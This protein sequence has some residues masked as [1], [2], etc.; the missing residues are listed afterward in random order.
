[1]RFSQLSLKLNPFCKKSEPILQNEPIRILYPFHSPFTKNTAEKDTFSAVF[2][3][4]LRKQWYIIAVGVY[5]H[6]RCISSTVGCIS[7]AMM[8]YSS[9]N[10]ICSLSNGWYAI[11]YEIDDIQGFRLDFDVRMWYN[12]LKEVILCQRIICWYIPNSLRLILNWCAKALKR[13]QT[14]FFKSAKAQA[15]FM[16]ISVRQITVKVKQTCFQNSK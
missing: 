5:H 6:R 4:P 12:T 11:S 8:I 10:E 2:F 16:P 3:Y 7:F 9:E 14:R 13:H 15:V 1:M